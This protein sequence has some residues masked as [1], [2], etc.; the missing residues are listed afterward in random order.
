MECL[1]SEAMDLSR[2][3]VPP[4]EALE[5]VILKKGRSVVHRISSARAAATKPKRVLRAREL[6]TIQHTG[7][8]S[9]DAKT[10][11]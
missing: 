7:H 4:G 3:L 1:Q 5:V 9:K 11:A 6:V 2:F 10:S 8:R